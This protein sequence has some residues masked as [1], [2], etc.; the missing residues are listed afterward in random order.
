[1]TALCAVAAFSLSAC[2]G[3]D[4]AS[5]E[6]ADKPVA[7]ADTSGGSSAS[8][9]PSPSA[10][11]AAGRPKIELPADLTYDFEWPKTGDAKKDAVMADT[12]QY[13]QAVDMAIARQDP[14]DPA[15]RFYTA[16]E[17]AAGAQAYVQR[18]VDTHDRTTG[19]MRYSK[20]NVQI[21]DDDT[22][23]FTYCEDQS[24]AYRKNVKT[25]KTKVTPATKD[26]YVLYNARLRL[27]GKGVWVTEK[28]VSDAGSD[29]C[30]P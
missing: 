13:L 17:S 3:G 22:A 20:P 5:D 4:D 27:N 25:G 29:L 14:D 2:G 1:M 16:G 15:F 18:F 9:G 12:R 21:N 24:K 11:T 30:Q 10:S 26:G 28:L 8:A 7:G 6:K 23:G 19:V